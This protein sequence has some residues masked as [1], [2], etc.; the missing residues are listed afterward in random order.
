MCL[1][2]VTLDKAR[3][4]MIIICIRPL[5]TSNKSTKILTTPFVQKENCDVE[6]LNIMTVSPPPLLEKAINQNRPLYNISRNVFIFISIADKR[7]ESESCLLN[8]LQT[9][10]IQCTINI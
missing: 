5:T 2:H 4:I 3:K 10:T 7:F 8:R 1:P 6:Y 9:H